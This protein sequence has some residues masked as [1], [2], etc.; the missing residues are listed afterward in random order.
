MTPKW[1]RCSRLPTVS[2]AALFLS[3]CG[4]Y[5][6]FTLPNVSG[7]DPTL[8]FAFDEHPEPV[9]TR[10]SAHDVLAPSVAGR[11]LFYSAWD[12]KTWS[13]L[14]A[15]PTS[16]TTWQPGGAVLEPDPHTWEGSYIAGNGAALEVNGEI[17]YWYVA[18]PRDR[19]RIGL[20]RNWRKEPRPVLEP[21]PY[22]S[23]DEYG[24][25]D[26]Y[27]IR[28]SDTF[29]LYYLGEDRAWRQ[30]LGVAR[31]TD[32]IHWQKLR[33]NPILETGPPASF[34]E[35]LGEPA[36]WQSDG[37]YWMLYTGRA[38][39]EQRRL[40]LARS[41]DGVNWTKLPAIFSGAHAWD[42][43]VICDPTVR[44]REVWFGGGDIASPDENL[45]GQIGYGVLRPVRVTV[46]K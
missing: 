6:D 21:G 42:S 39:N 36:V 4:H 9:L 19:P 29:Y 28:L 30:R 1:G 14:R 10:G 38:A 40:G 8:T 18:G 12:G 35:N 26:P 3:A 11:D 22:M 20:A 32:G 17:W 24:V 31:S 16:A 15:T 25:A 43:Q 33:T 13:T 23:W 7:G 5:S 45:H 41:T 2:L 37:F 34:D 46:G 44:G 27:V